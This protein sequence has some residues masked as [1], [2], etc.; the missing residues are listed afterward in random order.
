MRDVQ[1]TIADIANTI[2]EFEPVVMLMHPDQGSVAQKQL[3]TQV[4]IWPIPTDDLWCRDSGPLFV[5]DGRGRIGHQPHEFQR[6][7]WKAASRQRWKG[8]DGG[9]QRA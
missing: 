2:S 5:I 6:M 3:S 1:A 8:G 7:G 4:E 9:G